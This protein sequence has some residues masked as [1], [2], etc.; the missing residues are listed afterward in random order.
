MI[1]SAVAN[2]EMGEFAGGREIG[3]LDLMDVAGHAFLDGFDD[4]V[5]FVGGAFQDEFDAAVGEVADVASDVMAES[6]I[7][8][9]VAEAD[10]LNTTAEMIVATMN[11]GG[12]SQ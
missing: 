11:Q 4:A 5:D 9:G 10:S 7:A 6:D 1:F 3:L 8:G 2:G 12:F